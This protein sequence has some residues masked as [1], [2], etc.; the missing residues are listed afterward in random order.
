M[1]YH[2]FKISG[3]A[4]TMIS[5]VFSAEITDVSGHYHTGERI[6]NY[7]FIIDGYFKLTLTLVCFCFLFD[8]D[9]IQHGFEVEFW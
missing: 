5:Q 4:T 1:R 9:L 7:A 8:L 2:L 6:G 3:T